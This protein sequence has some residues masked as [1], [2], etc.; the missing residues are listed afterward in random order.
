MSFVETK[1]IAV[2]SLFNVVH[3]KFE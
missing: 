1:K 3:W 2:V